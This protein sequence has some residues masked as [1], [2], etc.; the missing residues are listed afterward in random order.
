MNAIFHPIRT[1]IMTFL[2]GCALAH[3]GLILTAVAGPVNA[4]DG[5][6]GCRSCHPGHRPDAVH[7]LAC[8]TCHGGQERETDRDAAHQGLVAKPADPEHMAAACG[9]CHGR[10][11]AEVTRSLHF[12][13]SNKINAVRAH[14]DN[15]GRLAKLTDIPETTTPATAPALVDDLLR[16]RCL[17]CHLFSPGDDYAAVTRGVGCAA[18]HLGFAGGK[19]ESHA[20][21]RPTDQQCLGCHY[22]NYVGSDYHGR[23]EHDYHGEYRTPYTV[24]GY[25]PRPHGVEYH[26]L[27]PDLHQQRG[28]GCIDCHDHAGHGTQRELR[29]ATCHDWWP[30]K[31]VPKIRSLSLRDKVLFLTPSAG[32]VSRPVPPMR[33]PAHV[34]FAR[35]VACQVCHGQ[36]SFNDATTH[37]LLTHSDDFEPWERLTVQSSSE[38]ES[39]LEHHLYGNA[40]RAVT[41]R[42]GLTGQPKP[43]VWLQGYTQRRWEQMLVAKDQDGVIKVFRPILDLRLSVMNRDGSVPF[44]NLAGRDNGLRPY[45][46][47]TT[48]P[49]GLFFK[50][51][52]RHLLAP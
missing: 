51:R 43:G 10:Q 25:P 39:L 8:A 19:P 11:V 33:D 48:G 30:G 32:G 29:C 42:D 52:F 49:A 14:F 2:L 27:A 13:L 4:A 47:H 38:V 40:E 50:D 23:Y 17:R 44:D 31:P 24:A 18:C 5:Q 37:L 1:V 20:F 41:M 45:T 46:P 28:L 36:W 3:A 35:T 15:E 9:S 7:D 34:T 21:V 6:A 16:R 26:N 22:G 12:T